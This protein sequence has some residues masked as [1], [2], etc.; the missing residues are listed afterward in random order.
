MLIS[1]LD[2]YNSL[3][4]ENKKIIKSTFCKGP[5]E[6]ALNVSI[7]RIPH[8]VLVWNSGTGEF[9][10]HLW[11]LW[12]FRFYTI[13]QVNVSCMCIH[14]VHKQVFSWWLYVK[15]SRIQ[16]WGKE[17]NEG[18]KLTNILMIVRK[19]MSGRDA[20]VASSTHGP[21]LEEAHLITA[22]ASTR[23]FSIHLSNWSVL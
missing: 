13:L 9:C 14:Y 16:I 15:K 18:P 12:S 19:E 11:T 1:S 23:V 17:S 22:T 2:A 10:N 5:L 3:Q 21:N 20:S 4:K 8:K 6:D 7:L